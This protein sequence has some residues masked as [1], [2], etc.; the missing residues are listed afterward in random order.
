MALLTRI[1]RNVW[2]HPSCHST[3]QG[4]FLQSGF[5]TANIKIPGTAISKQCVFEKLQYFDF[6]SSGSAQVEMKCIY[7]DC[8]HQILDEIV[9][10]CGVTCMDSGNEKCSCF[11]RWTTDQFYFH[12][13][14]WT[15]WPGYW[16]M[17]YSRIS[18]AFCRQKNRFCQFGQGNVDAFF[19]KH[20][21]D[22]FGRKRCSTV[23]QCFFGT[24]WPT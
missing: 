24:Y 7:I 21:R 11:C 17:N 9:W 4:L 22:I 19:A 5:D 8:A 12:Q 2:V 23:K 6:V 20:G 1:R 3:H 15:V 18:L 16:K 10:F 14:N 13:Q